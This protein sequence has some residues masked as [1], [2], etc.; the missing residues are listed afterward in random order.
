MSSRTT[1]KS[2]T[3]S[4]SLTVPLLKLTTLE[5]LQAALEAR[6]Y[7]LRDAQIDAKHDPNDDADDDDEENALNPWNHRQS[8]QSS[9][10][11]E[12]VMT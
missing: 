6:L 3:S 7:V 4:L 1:R 12:R 10:F 9:S 2:S 8:T 5:Q 11:P